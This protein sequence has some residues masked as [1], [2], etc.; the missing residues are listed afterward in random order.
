MLKILNPKL[1]SFLE[2]HFLR[3]QRMVKKMPFALDPNF[4][5]LQWHL[6]KEAKKNNHAEVAALVA[7]IESAKLGIQNLRE[8]LQQ[9]EQDHNSSISDLQQ[10]IQDLENS[11]KNA[12]DEL[13]SK[14]SLI[15][16][17]E[18][19]MAAVLASV[20]VLEAELAAALAALAA[21]QALASSEEKP[22]SEEPMEPVDVEE[23]NARN[24][25]RTVYEVN[26]K[27]SSLRGSG[28]DSRVFMK[29]FGAE[30][31]ETGD[32][33]LDNNPDNFST[34][35]NDFFT[36]RP[37]SQLDSITKIILGHDNSGFGPTWLCDNVKIKTR[38]TEDT[39]FFH[40]GKWFSSRMGDGL[41]TR[42]LFP[43]DQR[44]PNTPVNYKISVIT[45]DRIG[46]S[47]DSEI[48]IQL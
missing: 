35:R 48:F 27:T 31:Q 9:L 36:V 15:S 2:D 23:E 38:Q 1:D 44:D 47:T 29:L 13:N 20:A 22:A 19:E 34:G 5:I 42:E 41:T 21:A 33:Y 14:N 28:T 43:E 39:W 46:A 4:D 12:Y 16:K 32:L 24:G 18:A 3:S 45:G 40:V 30:G 25:P 17:H 10:Q 37:A 7:K 11:K 26:I 6:S 8:K